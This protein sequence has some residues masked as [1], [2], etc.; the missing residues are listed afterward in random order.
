M[1]R[2]A[3]VIGDKMAETKDLDAAFFTELC[4]VAGRLKSDPA[5]MLGVMMSESGVQAWAHNPNGHA[6]GLIQF[7]PKTLLNLDWTKGPEAFRKL[8]AT[9]QLRYVEL[10]FKSY[11]GYLDSVAGLYTATFLPALVKHCDDPE[12][13]LTAKNGPLGWA[14]APN[15]VFDKNKDYAITVSELEAAVERNC[16]GKRWAEIIARLTGSGIEEFDDR[17]VRDLRTTY[18]IQCTLTELGLHPG[19]LDGIPGPKT[20]AAVMEFQTSYGLEPDGIVGPLTRNALE[21]SLKSTNARSPG[22]QTAGV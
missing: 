14:Y 19:A 5:K 22:G 15:S 20:T 18:G 12:F 17:D 16:T 13:V 2:T 4:A 10:Y 3:G 7:M 8:S 11:I 1:R 6:S 9:Q 21:E